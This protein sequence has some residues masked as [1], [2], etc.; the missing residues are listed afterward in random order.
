MSTSDPSNDQKPAHD[1]MS[2]QE[3]LAQASQ[4]R[5]NLADVQAASEVIADVAWMLEEMAQENNDVC[6]RDE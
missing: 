4:S 3:A 1:P 2:V 6:P 5:A